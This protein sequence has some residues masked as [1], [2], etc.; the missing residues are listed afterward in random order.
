MVWLHA[1]SDRAHPSLQLLLDP[2]PARWGLRGDPY[3]WQEL[4]QAL[5]EQPLPPSPAAADA[6][7]ASLYCQLVGEAP[8]VGRQPFVARYAHGG[9]SS[10]RVAADFWLTQGFPLLKKRLLAQLP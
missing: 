5:A 9:L 6:L 3:L 8:N 4:T 10:G 1:L 7:L 2:P